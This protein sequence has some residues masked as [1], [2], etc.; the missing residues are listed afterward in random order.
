VNADSKLVRLSDL[1]WRAQAALPTLPSYLARLGGC[2]P[3]SLAR[4][5][6]ELRIHAGLLA[7]H[8][9]GDPVASG[10]LELV[11]IA[12]LAIC[13]ERPVLH[14]LRPAACGLVHTTDLHT[15]PGEPPRLL[16]RAWLVEVRR[17]ETGDRLFGDTV[18]LGGYAFD[19]ATYLVG[20]EWPETARVSRWVPRWGDA[21]LDAGV[22]HET[23]PMIDDVD[24]HHAWAR[25][26][27]R[28]AV[29]LGVLLDAEGTPIRI[30]TDAPPAKKRQRGRGGKQRERDTWT[31]RHVYLD[32]L[33]APRP[34]PPTSRPAPLT[35][36]HD[37]SQT[38]DGLLPTE[39]QVR[40]HLKKQ[41]YGPGRT[42][43][44]WIYVESYEARRWVAPG[45]IRVV[46]D[47]KARQQ[48]H[49]DG[50]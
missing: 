32:E 12:A 25:E 24:T 27:A 14:L 49:D 35:S 47:S 20:L 15:L 11:N 2:D 34:A 40:G 6:Q 28:F 42:K 44:R 16:Q 45:P 9:F 17:P 1:V 30:E 46:V 19:G 29:V 13:L 39:S 37:D 4:I 50:T 5:R 8:T 22:A 18:Y 10:A 31:T 33:R 26:A 41:P 36:A 38:T 23:S 21:E 3:D 48:T 43:R 7:M